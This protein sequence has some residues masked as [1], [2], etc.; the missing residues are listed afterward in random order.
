M[1]I[2]VSNLSKHD[3]IFTKDKFLKLKHIKKKNTYAVEVKAHISATDRISRFLSNLFGTQYRNIAKVLNS[4]KGQSRLKRVENKAVRTHLNEINK[5]ITQLNQKA[6]VRYIPLIM[7]P[8]F[9]RSSGTPLTRTSGHRTGSKSPRGRSRHLLRPNKLLISFYQGVGANC[10]RRTL[11]DIW[12]LSLEDKEKT[13]NFIQWLFPLTTATIYNRTAPILNPGLIKDLKD[14]P[15]FIPNLRRSLNVMLEFF[16]LEWEDET[17]S[18]IILSSNFEERALCWLN[19]G[20]HN[21][22]RITRI[23]ESLRIFELE[24]EN[25]A[26]ISILEVIKN[27]YPQK[28]SEKAWSFWEQA[29]ACES[30]V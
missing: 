19:R 9:T 22:H 26:L 10:Q 30:N 18:K 24:K 15:E 29:C 4:P 5:K 16:G 3:T 11:N 25:K 14:L 21:H 7:I 2:S 12:N 1:R 20:N 8:E 27:Q 28:I 6:F 23:L 17:Q 13:H